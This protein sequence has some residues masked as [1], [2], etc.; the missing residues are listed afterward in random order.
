MQVDTLCHQQIYVHATGQLGCSQGP[1][2]ST[3]ACLQGTDV[4]LLASPP[5]RSHAMMSWPDS[6]PGCPDVFPQPVDVAEF[7][8][9]AA[10]QPTNPYDRS[11]F[12]KFIISA[13]CL[14]RHCFHVRYMHQPVAVDLNAELKQLACA[15]Y[16]EAVRKWPDLGITHVSARR[17][18]QYVEE[19]DLHRTVQEILPLAWND[20]TL[21]V[22]LHAS[23]PVAGWSELPA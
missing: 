11:T 23:R 19:P 18:K 22:R 17:L 3:T 16:H 1:M 9:G 8:H 4:P 12:V 2:T 13:Q 15:I 5:P 20:E 10:P 14:E 6:A 7:V 21:N